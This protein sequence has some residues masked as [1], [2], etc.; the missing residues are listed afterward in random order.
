[1][2]KILNKETQK[3]FLAAGIHVVHG[4]HRPLKGEVPEILQTAKPHCLYFAGF[5]DDMG[6]WHL[7]YTTFNENK[8]AT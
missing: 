1:M 7:Y 2:S 8:K 3:L 6:A 4:V 5:I